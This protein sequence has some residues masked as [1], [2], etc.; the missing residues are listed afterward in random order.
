MLSVPSTHLTMME[1]TPGLCHKK[2]HISCM[3]ILR[4]STTIA[5]VIALL[6]YM[7]DTDTIPT[8]NG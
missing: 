8:K 3:E 2:I 5:V 1:A 7:T 4:H 6:Q